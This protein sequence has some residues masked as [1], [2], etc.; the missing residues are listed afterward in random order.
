MNHITSRRRLLAGCSALAAGT[1]LGGAAFAKAPEAKQAARMRV[2]IDNDVAGDPDGLFQL[3]HFV[4]CPSVS[5]PLVI[6]SHYKDFGEADLVPQKGRASAR[7]AEELLTFFAPK[8]RPPVI[9]GTGQPI[10]S[11]SQPGTSPA[12]AAII[13]EAMRDDVRAPLY[14]A[15][16]GSLTEIALAWL[17]EPKI[18]KRLKLLWIGGVEHADLAIAPAGPGEAEYNFSLDRLAAQIVFNESDIEIWQVPRNA[19]R[20]MLVGVSELEELAQ[21]GPLGRYLRQQVIQTEARLAKNLPSFI[22]SQGETY[23]LGDCAL[24]TLTALQSAFQP[25]TSSSRHSLRPTP[26]LKL[27]GSYVANPAGRPMRVYDV[28]DS[29]LTW[30]DMLAKLRYR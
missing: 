27:E 5:I 22:Y 18:G 2:I 12:S 10:L 1:L 20:Q 28:V 29:G 6:G 7:K 13:R 23:A 17:A 30:R 16:G 26:H 4:M 9:A 11:R 3:A 25:D 15:A 19:F 8:Q 14:Y 24:V 21:L